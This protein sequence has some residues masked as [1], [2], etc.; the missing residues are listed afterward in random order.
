MVYMFFNG[1]MAG[2]AASISA[3]ELA[4]FSSVSNERVCAA[5]RTTNWSAFLL[6]A[7]SIV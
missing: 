1:R 3:L 2:M 5:S 4:I 7:F 6:A